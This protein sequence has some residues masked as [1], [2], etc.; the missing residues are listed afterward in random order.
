MESFEITAL[1]AQ[2]RDAVALAA[3][4]KTE[5]DES[6]S[7]TSEKAKAALRLWDTATQNAIRLARN[8]RLAGAEPQTLDDELHDLLVS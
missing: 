2:F 5:L 3:R 4:A 7:L 8:L 6:R 1:V